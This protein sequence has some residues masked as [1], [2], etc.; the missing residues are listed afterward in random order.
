MPRKNHFRKQQTPRRVLRDLDGYISNAS[1]FVWG[2]D[3]L[4][5]I[6]EVRQRHLVINLPAAIPEGAD[7]DDS[8]DTDIIISFT[9][10]HWTEPAWRR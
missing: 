3:Y 2:E 9:D 6:R 5:A 7:S 8:S 10:T 4:H 1:D